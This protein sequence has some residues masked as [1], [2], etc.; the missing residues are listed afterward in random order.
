[1]LF[2]ILLV[3]VDNFL[4]FSLVYEGEPS[5]CSTCCSPVK[6]NFCLIPECLSKRG[7]IYQTKLTAAVYSEL[8][9]ICRANPTP[10]PRKLRFFWKM[11]FRLRGKSFPNAG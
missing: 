11:N 9:P 2:P 6:E 10:N 4:F 7:Q 1:M 5:H 3:C 8:I